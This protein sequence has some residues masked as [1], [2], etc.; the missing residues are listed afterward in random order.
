MLNLEETEF[1]LIH[2]IDACKKCLYLFFNESFNNFTQQF[3][4]KYIVV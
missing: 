1:L 4:L 2:K 3:E